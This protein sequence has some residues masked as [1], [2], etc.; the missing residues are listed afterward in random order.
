MQPRRIG[1]RHA[2]SHLIAKHNPIRGFVMRNTPLSHPLIRVVCCAVLL[3]HC[4]LTAFAAS[5]KITGRIVDSK[6]GEGL[7]SANIVITHVVKDDGREVVADHLIGGS[8]DVDGYYFI[9]N[10]PPGTYVLK[11]S[12]LGYSSVVQKPIRVDMDRT[13]TVNFNLASST[14]QVDQVVVIAQRE[15]IRKDVSATQEVI[16]TTR[17]EAMP[18][19]RMDEFA[20]KMKGVELV[21]GPEGNGLSVR[22]GAIRETD[23]RL[24]GI[25]LRDP[26]SDNSYLALNSTSIEEIQVLTGGFEAKYGGIRSG[27]LNVVTKDGERERY[28]VSLKADVAPSGQQRFFGTNPWSN[29]SWIYKVF[30]GQYAMDGIQTHADSMAVP[31]D[32]WTFK[33][34]RNTTAS[35]DAN[36]LLLD[37][38]QKLD[39]WQQQHPQYSLNGKP[40]VYL[41][42]SITGPV[43]G[44]GIPLLGSYAERTTF[45]LGF[46]YE[47]TQLAFPLGPRDNYL[48]WNTQLKLTSQLG[49]NVR[50]SL[51]GLYA[52]IKSVSGGS[53]T[54]YG[55]AL[56]DASSS[57]GFLNSTESSV[58]QQARL[59]AGSE[60]LA[61]MFNK[62]RLQFYDQQYTVGGAKLTHTFSP[63]AFYTV[64]VQGGYT[65]QNLAPFA[66]DTSRAD[67]WITYAT[68][69]TTTP[70]VRFLR[71]PANGSPN[72]STNPGYDPLGYFRMYGGLQR[73]DSSHSWVAQ[74]KGDLTT[75]LG[76][77]HQVEAGFSAL[78]QDIFVYT[79]TWS[80]TQIAFT[81]DEW[82]YYKATPL[83]I[84]AYAQDKL[85]FEGMILNA[86]VRLDYFNPMKKGY[87]VGFPVDQD[88]KNF[89]EKVYI[90]APGAWG[91]YERW[92][93]FRELLENPSGWLRT[94]NRVQ[95]YVSPRLG[96]SFPI[97]ESSKMYFNYGHFYQRPPTSF[98]YNQAIYI[99]AVALP[100][101]N[102]DMART[103]SYEFGYEQMFFSDFLLNVT[104]YYKDNRNEPLSR[105]F[106]NYYNDND[107]YQY[108]PDAYSDVRGVEV[109]L[110]RPVGRF[111]S[112]NA[113]YDYQVYSGGQVGLSQVY[114]D[115]LKARTE[116]ETR[117]AY[118]DSPDPIPRANVSL[119]LHT[120][121]EFGPEFLGVQWLSKIVMNVFFE[122]KDG[123]RYLWNPEVSDVKDRIY[124]DR[125]N[126]WNIDLRASKAF[127]LSFASM[128]I[129][130]TI[131]NLTDNKWLN[132]A[133]MTRFQLDEYKASLNPAFKKQGGN[134]QWGQWKSDD[135]H[136][137]TGWWEAPIFLNPRQI[138]VGMRLNF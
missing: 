125:V 21:S 115:R 5:G 61:Q 2:G 69:N 133:N 19:I 40:N 34:W 29:D 25:S 105:E 114:E 1:R 41:E 95:A 85:E 86:G 42:G 14:I 45:L 138:L 76:R 48:D 15:I 36:F 39:L 43:P 20:G 60:G 106:I 87:V 23:V 66:L 75:Q 94:E 27:L 65:S 54:S 132:V 67:A 62:S 38:A 24:D 121:G 58:S 102:L 74:L 93:Y 81:P 113:M 123:G 134:D 101:P 26:R 44:A 128:E 122:W 32:F 90:N 7:P 79:G 117:S 71:S 104:A 52:K 89:Y 107:V 126:Y 110:E 108:Y 98:L 11:A 80:Q 17:L 135:G 82:Q 63:T 31:S 84:G 6:N 59:L 137:K 12:V 119:N 4:A 111:V 127:D 51:N 99:G 33:G 57:F 3:T 100:T 88:F 73:A 47:N 112:F 56:V 35:S 22:G 64:D 77:H 130:L 28:T 116:G 46:K 16:L 8:S 55:G 72:G 131:K 78:Y 13:I 30:A 136:I 118:L 37:S 49:D 109:R 96:V 70:Y 53:V 92:L 129:V 124:I 120:P 68:K 97:T 18:V 9:M 50:L 91:S 83:E 103:V 10:V